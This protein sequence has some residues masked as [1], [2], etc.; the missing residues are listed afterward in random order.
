MNSS[1]LRSS[2]LDNP[3]FPVPSVQTLK[4]FRDTENETLLTFLINSFGSRDIF[5]IY[6]PNKKIHEFAF[7][8]SQ[9][10][11]ITKIH[12]IIG[13]KFFLR[14]K[15]RHYIWGCMQ[16]LFHLHAFAFSSPAFFSLAEISDYSR[17]VWLKLHAGLNCEEY[18]SHLVLPCNAPWWWDWIRNASW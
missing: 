16:S 17:V 11:L 1:V 13:T 9:N 14:S 3:L 15:S 12:Q 4:M 5:Y 6:L 18:D 10:A 7:L 2:Y 8:I